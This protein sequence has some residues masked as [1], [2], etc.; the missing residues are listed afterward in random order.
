MPRIHMLQNLHDLADMATVAEVIDSQ[1]FSKFYSM[2]SSNQVP[3]GDTIGHFC[4]LPI[5][6]GLQEKLFAQAVEL[7]Q[8]RGLILKKGKIVDSANS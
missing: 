6:H 2:D 5:K 7:L 1:T 8:K 4:R 3:D